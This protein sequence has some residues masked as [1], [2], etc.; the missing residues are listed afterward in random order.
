MA[1]S[2]IWVRDQGGDWFALSFL[3][4]A[5][6]LALCVVVGIATYFMT[7]YLIGLTPAKLRVSRIV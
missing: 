1:I 6:G 4:R 7:C 3:G 2:V 5:A